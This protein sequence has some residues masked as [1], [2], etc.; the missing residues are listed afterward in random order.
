MSKYSDNL[1]KALKKIEQA[2]SYIQDIEAAGFSLPDYYKKIPKELE[3]IKNDPNRQGIS[4][5]RLNHIRYLFNG[6]IIKSR[7]RIDTTYSD[8][9]A[10]E[11]T[12]KESYRI[13]VETKL[14]TVRVAPL[15]KD[16]FKYNELNKFGKAVQEA[17]T[18]IEDEMGIVPNSATNTN[19][20]LLDDVLKDVNTKLG[21]NYDITQLSELNRDINQYNRNIVGTGLDPIDPNTFDSILRYAT[22]A[23]AK[24]PIGATPY[25]KQIEKGMGD[26]GTLKALG[27]NMVDGVNKGFGWSD[28]EI[29]NFI[30]FVDTSAFW[31]QIHKEQ[32]ESNSQRHR[33]KTFTTDI[34]DLIMKGN[35]KNI[36]ELR[37][38]LRNGDS[39]TSI[40]A[41]LQ[42]L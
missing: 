42:T 41:W 40:E 20:K 10:D 30:S 38:K 32:F 33:I 13:N 36:N 27:V 15:G 11:G 28:E 14:G 3:D 7:A 2:Q 12:D 26:E 18:T 37:R 34:K 25:R 35:S 23:I 9:K 5:E 31:K 16:I 1:N 39:Y 22:N 8:V 6:N 24:A 29:R 4:D 17:L 19:V 21:T